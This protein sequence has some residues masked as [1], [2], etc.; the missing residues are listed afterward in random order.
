MAKGF[1]GEWYLGRKERRDVQEQA[2][3][4][5]DGALQ[6]V[7]RSCDWQALTRTT[8]WNS[9]RAVRSRVSRTS[10]TYT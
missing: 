1:W 3:R 10:G 7:D 5:G 9:N 6:S 4:E 8:T 2:R